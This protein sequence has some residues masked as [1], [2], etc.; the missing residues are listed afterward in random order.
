MKPVLV[1][2]LGN[3]VLSDDAFGFHVANRLQESDDLDERVEVIYAS[4]AGF[5]LLDL[6]RDRT[7]LLIVDTIV[8]SRVAPGELHF[9]PMGQFAPSYGLTT[10][11]QLS[12]PTALALGEKL[13]M[14]M[15]RDIDVLAVEAQD[16]ATLSEQLTPPVQQ[17]LMPAIERIRNW[18][19]QQTQEGCHV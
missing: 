4:L 16:I 10:S 15:P 14:H 1:L 11:H 6:I 3:E 19:A 13:G 5:N 18:V 17:A 7:K 8:T 2:C 12:L 9:F